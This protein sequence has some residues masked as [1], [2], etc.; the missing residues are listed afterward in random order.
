M[1]I[2]L[3]NF[4]KLNSKMLPEIVPIFDFWFPKSD[5]PQSILI[6]ILDHNIVYQSA[7]RYCVVN[8]VILL[9]K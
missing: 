7:V 9:S 2:L 4:Y 5:W 1:K 3:V 6:I 8:Y